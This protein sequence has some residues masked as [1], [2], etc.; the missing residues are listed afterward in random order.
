MGVHPL[1][2]VLVLLLPTTTKYETNK[3]NRQSTYSLLMNGTNNFTYQA[4]PPRLIAASETEL[5]NCRNKSTIL[6]P[7]FSLR[8]TLR[9]GILV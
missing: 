2:L 7:G 1:Y 6:F 5:A 8:T 4:L 9:L 3:V